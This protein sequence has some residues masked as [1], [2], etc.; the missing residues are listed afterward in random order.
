VVQGMKR[1]WKIALIIVV[2][3]AID[4]VGHRLGPELHYNDA[5]SIFEN[6]ALF[7]PL[8]AILFIVTFGVLAVVFVS[9]EGNLP[10]SRLSRGLQYGVAFGVLWLIG[11]LG[12]SPAAGSPITQE[13]YTGM[14]DGSAVIL[15]A[16]LLARFAGRDEALCTVRKRQVGYGAIPVIAVFYTG[17]YFLGRWLLQFIP[18]VTPIHAPN[19]LH[20][21]IVALGLGGWIGVMYVLLAQG[22]G[23][24][25]PHKQALW[26]GVVVFG[27]QWVLFAL[28][29]FLFVE[30]S[31]LLPLLGAGMDIVFVVAAVWVYERFLSTIGR[32]ADV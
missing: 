27:L 24:L 15:L 28:F 13:L 29:G 30:Q 7:T 1:I 16:V 5:S 12:V 31:L 26:F 11:I 20:A 23:G 3:L 14:V 22:A 6:K 32:V 2:C 21:L 18:S 9:I 17:S 8:I 10:G 4:M 25:V 19:P